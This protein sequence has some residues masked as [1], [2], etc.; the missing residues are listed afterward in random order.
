MFV[1]LRYPDATEYRLTELPK[2]TP[3]LIAALDS[4]DATEQERETLLRFLCEGCTE[5]SVLSYRAQFAEELFAN[6]ALTQ[7]LEEFATLRELYEKEKS[8]TRGQTDAEKLR[9]LTLFES[10]SQRFDIFAKKLEGI[11]PESAAAKRFLMF[12]RTFSEKFEYKELKIKGAELRRRLDLEQGFLLYSEK[13]AAKSDVL[14]LRKGPDVSAGV[15]KSVEEMKRELGAEPPPKAPERFRPYTDLEA[16]IITGILRKDPK[17]NRALDEFLRL[18]E[19]SGTEDLLKLS[20]EATCFCLLNRLYRNAQAHGYTAT[21]PTFREPGFYTE[22]FGLQYPSSEG[23]V[24]T[25][26]YE[27]SPLNHVTV[28]FG[29]DSKSYGAAVLF[30]HRMAAVGGLVFAKKAELSPTEQWSRDENKELKTENLTEHGFCLCRNLFDGMLPR[31]EDAAVT[32]VLKQLAGRNVRSVVRI[33]HKSNL[34]ALE[35]KAEDGIIPPFTPLQAGQDSTL[36]E[37]LNRHK[38]TAQHLEEVAHDGNE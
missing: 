29:P 30:A 5:A 19:A 22:I 15:W 13:P 38:L 35:K 4:I 10:F 2:D 17:L 3:E 37:L 23:E 24:C 34:S 33:C 16:A 20:V 18:Y 9:K 27:T 31:Q 21:R 28:V 8:V 36:E 1:S 14:T 11:Y 7:C 25:A 12:C 26:D 6:D 32:E